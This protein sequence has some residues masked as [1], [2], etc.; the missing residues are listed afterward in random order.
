MSLQ[1]GHKTGDKAHKLSQTI[2]PHIEP[3]CPKQKQSTG[4]SPTTHSHVLNI[5]SQA[6]NHKSLISLSANQSPT[7]YVNDLCPLGMGCV[8]GA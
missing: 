7:Y 1:S 8:G 6:V 2:S 4:Q 3:C 5:M